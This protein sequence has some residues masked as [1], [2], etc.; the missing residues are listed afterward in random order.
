ME[1]LYHAGTL[2]AIGVSNFEPRHIDDILDAGSVTPALNQVERHAYLTQAELH[3]YC[4]AHGIQLA[5][6]GSVGAKG[7]LEDP[8]VR[9]IAQAHGRTPAQ[10]SLKYSMQSGIVVLA[11][12]ITEKRIA[13]NSKLFDFEL[14]KDDLARLDALDCGQRSYW[15]NSDV[16]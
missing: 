15:D 8:I 3:E 5:A 1:D 13:K 9:D 14:T 11:K 2:K 7:L 10:V 16:P 4:S 12:S 6:Y